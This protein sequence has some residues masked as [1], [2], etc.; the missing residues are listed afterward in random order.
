[1]SVFTHFVEVKLVLFVRQK[2][3]QSSHIYCF[4]GVYKHEGSSTPQI[5]RSW[6]AES[7]DENA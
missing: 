4:T 7:C 1:M 3:S 2:S 5:T 6:Q